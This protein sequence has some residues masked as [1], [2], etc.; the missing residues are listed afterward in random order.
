MV[1]NRPQGEPALPP[2][3]CPPPAG[4]GEPVWADDQ[5]FALEQHVIAFSAPDSALP[6]AR[7]DTLCDLFL[8]EPLG[9]QARC[10][11]WRWRRAWTTAPSVWRSKVHRAMVDGK[12]AVELAL[13]L[14][15]LE[16]DGVA[17]A[18]EPWDPE[19]AP[20]ATRLAVEVFWLTEGADMGR[21]GAGS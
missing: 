12:S 15:A 18:P 19:V 11:A 10:G 1:Q 7:F 4:L 14:L 20:G 17:A 3:P 16:P 5:R 9:R 21:K 8:S 13:P 6:R 2:A